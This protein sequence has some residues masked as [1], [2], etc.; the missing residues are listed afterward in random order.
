MLLAACHKDDHTEQTKEVAKKND[1]RTV[2]VYVA[3]DNNLTS[4]FASDLEQMMQG[5]KGVSSDNKLILFVDQQGKKPFFMQVENGD[6]LRL[7]TM[8]AELK[9]SDPETLYEAL[10][11]AAVNFPAESYGLV[12]WGHADGWITRGSDAAAHAAGRGAAPKRAYGIDETGRK[13]WMNIP[14]MAE[15]LSRRLSDSQELAKL[16]FIVADCCCFMCVENVYELRNCADCIIGSPAEIPGEGAPYHTLVPAM[17]GRQDDVYSQIV[18]AYYAQESQGYKVPLTAVLTSKLDDLANATA[19]TLAEMATAIDADSDGC[20][21]PDVDSLIF[22]Y[23]HT[24]F[25]MQDFML[26]YAPAEQYAEW[27]RAYDAAVPCHKFAEVWMANHVKH[28]DSEGRV[29][30]EFKPTEERMGGLGMF[31]PQR[32]SDAAKWDN[33]QYFYKVYYLSNL[34]MSMSRMN[35]NIKGMQWYE[36][37][38]LADLGW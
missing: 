15:A 34:D 25:D 22:Y 37:A 23:D 2:L 21:Y 16:R 11:Y 35:S 17:F 6:T 12:L 9:S 5:M 10:K 14:G 26:R 20:R 18:E 13:T 28:S 1:R 8:P 38:R 3:G 19:A 30:A 36:A 29:F 7:K 4:Y 33:Q 31:V 32:D 24:Q 27:K